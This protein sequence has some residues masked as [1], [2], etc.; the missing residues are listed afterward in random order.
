MT[1]LEQMYRQWWRGQPVR[2]H[3]L[4]H[5]DNH[6]THLHLSFCALGKRLS[7]HSLWYWVVV[8]DSMSCTGQRSTAVCWVQS[9]NA[10]GSPGLEDIPTW[11]QY[12]SHSSQ[13][14]GG[15]WEQPSTA[16]MVCLSTSNCCNVN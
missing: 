15:H 14:C 8:V 5:L 2:N 10:P 11:G 12:H 6:R 7:K 1:C 16:Q 3:S 13:Q 9:V 4:I